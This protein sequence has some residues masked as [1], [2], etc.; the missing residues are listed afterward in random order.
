MLV[1]IGASSAYVTDLSQF[2]KIGSRVDS[3]NWVGVLQA[4]SPLS[5]TLIGMRQSVNISARL[6]RRIVSRFI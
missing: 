5:R 4:C 6:K 1:N 2:L 3:S